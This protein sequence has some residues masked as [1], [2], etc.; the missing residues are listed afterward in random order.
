M[1][2]KELKTEE[3]LAE[4]KSGSAERPQ[5]IFKHSTRCSISA[6]VRSRLERSDVPEG[7]DFY[8]LDLLRF[9]NISGRIETDFKVSHE[10]PQVLLIK[11]GNC[12]YNES[13]SSISMDEIEDQA[14]RYVR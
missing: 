6:M 10:S 7:I 4:I 8:Y 2:W 3:Q 9:R 14:K 12:V 11:D 1:K 5:L 13:H